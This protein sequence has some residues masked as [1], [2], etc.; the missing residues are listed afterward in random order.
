MNLHHT[1]SIPLFQC[2]R[3][4]PCCLVLSRHYS[5][6]GTEPYLSQ[7]W[8]VHS[9]CTAN[10]LWKVQLNNFGLSQ[11]SSSQQMSE[12]K[13]VWCKQCN[14]KVTE[15]PQVTWAKLGRQ[16]LLLSKVLFGTLPLVGGALDTQHPLIYPIRASSSHQRPLLATTVFMLR[17]TAG[18][19][20]KPSTP[21]ASAS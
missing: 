5:S 12:L 15:E 19:P 4:S 21:S 17:L 3:P 18:S 9:R 10:T 11:K 7:H 8:P 13:S 1:S 6:P 20:I 2:C 16:T 14:V